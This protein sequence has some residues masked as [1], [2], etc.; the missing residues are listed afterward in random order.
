[1]GSGMQEGKIYEKPTTASA[2]RY[3]LNWLGRR[4]NA[5]ICLSPPQDNRT[6]T[7][8]K[9]LHTIPS[10]GFQQQLKTKG[11]PKLSLSRILLRCKVVGRRGEKDG[12]LAGSG[13]GSKKAF[14]PQAS[15]RAE[16]AV[17]YEESSHR[18]NPR[19]RPVRWLRGACTGIQVCKSDD[20]SAISGS[21][22]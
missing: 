2:L 12:V 16:S 10:G 4:L 1:M 5:E 17:L 20:L 14:H 18:H 8:P 19:P 13:A 7:T 6:T 22:R 9:L 11:L 21:T 3:S 15:E